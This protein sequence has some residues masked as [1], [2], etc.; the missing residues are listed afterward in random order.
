MT[1]K[2]SFDGSFEL[3]KDDADIFIQ[4][5]GSAVLWQRHFPLLKTRRSIQRAECK[6]NLANLSPK[7]S[8][9]AAQ[10]IE[11]ATIEIGETQEAASDLGIVAME[12]ASG[13]AP[14]VFTVVLPW[15]FAI[16]STI[17]PFWVRP[18]TGR[19]VTK[20]SD[21]IYKAT[22]GMRL[23]FPCL[24]D[25]MQ[26]VALDLEQTGLDGGGTAQPP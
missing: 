25:F 22:I 15:R 24:S 17:V 3:T 6:K 4:I 16:C 10:S 14:I 9:V 7:S 18:D 2:L 12:R 1:A 5:S 13:A 23:G 20:P 21:R 11:C 26:D 19:S 8:F